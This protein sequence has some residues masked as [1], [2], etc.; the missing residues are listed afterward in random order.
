VYDPATDRW[1]DLTDMPTARSGNGAAFAAGTIFS[2]GGEGPRIF[3]EVEAYDIAARTWRR[4]PDLAI[5]VHGAGV[6]VLGRTLFAFGGGYRVG[7]APTRA[8]QVLA[9]G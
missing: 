3:P 9:I 7:L 8:C 1:S 2:V 6:A 5:P 4:L